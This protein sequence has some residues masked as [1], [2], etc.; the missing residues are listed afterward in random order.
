LLQQA[1]GIPEREEIGQVPRNTMTEAPYRASRTT[2]PPAFTLMKT[3]SHAPAARG[4]P[5]NPPVTR[6]PVIQA[7]K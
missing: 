6:R 5:I 2:D 4:N 3:K 7:M 1:F